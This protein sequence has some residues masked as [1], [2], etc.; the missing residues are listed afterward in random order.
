MK[1]ARKLRSLYLKDS[2]VLM[3]LSVSTIK[4]VTLSMYSSKNA[5]VVLMEELSAT[6]RL[7]KEIKNFWTLKEVFSLLLKLILN[8]ILK[9]DLD[10]VR[11]CMMRIM[12]LFC[13][14]R[15]SMLIFLC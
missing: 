9:E 12:I 10:L 14:N 1:N 5:N 3:I 2:L 13:K 7:V 11:F 8:V 4:K 15:S 6:V